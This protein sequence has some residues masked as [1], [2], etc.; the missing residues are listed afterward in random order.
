[1]PN[2]LVEKNIHRDLIELKTFRTFG[3]K[4][5]QHSDTKI[6]LRGRGENGSIP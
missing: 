5:F 1:M 3:L 6:Y 2:N 4:M